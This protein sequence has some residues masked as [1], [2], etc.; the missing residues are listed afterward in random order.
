MKD[1]DPSAWKTSVCLV[2]N[3]APHTARTAT[4]L[5][6]AAPSIGS[7]YQDHITF[8][9]QTF[10]SS[11]DGKPVG[12]RHSIPVKGYIRDGMECYDLDLPPVSA[13]LLVIG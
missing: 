9:G 4:M 3:S 13:V 2:D 10:T 7:T 8:G 12:D 6:L 11:T 1:T 5:T